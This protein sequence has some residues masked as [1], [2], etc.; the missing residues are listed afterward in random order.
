MKSSTSMPAGRRTIVSGSHR[1]MRRLSSLVLRISLMW[2]RLDQVRGLGVD[3]GLKAHGTSLNLIVADG[4][5]GVE[6]AR[7]P[8]TPALRVGVP[9]TGGSTIVDYESGHIRPS[10]APA[11]SRGRRHP[12][13]VT[14]TVHG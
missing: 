12:E 5:M 4:Q 13:P 7:R 14:K 9:G 2:D 10:G 3:D 6:L 1:R 8:G 11:M